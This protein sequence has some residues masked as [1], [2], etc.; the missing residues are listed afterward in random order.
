[1]RFVRDAKA[2]RM[3]TSA[4]VEGIFEVAEGFGAL[5][6]SHRPA[7]K[8]PAFH[9]SMNPDFYADEVDRA[10]AQQYALLG[11]L[12]VR[13]PNAETLAQLTRLQGTPTPLGLTHI[14]LAEA[15]GAVS[16]AEARSEFF[17]LFIGVGRGELMPYASYYLT[18]FL[19][20]LPLA[21]LRE[22]LGRLGLARAEKHYDPEDHIG[23]LCEI[24]SGLADGSLG[25]PAAEAKPFFARHLAPWAGRFFT[26][27]EMSKTGKF[28]RAVG[29][30]GRT[31]ME[32]EAEAFALDD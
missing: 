29:A 18:G 6:A 4:G 22:D 17:G 1:L 9:E 24:M 7:P 5:P 27:L 32:I 19:Q 12:L 11:A 28:Y 2:R 26:D 14:A 15:A 16:E 21:R 20:D 30:V 3:K 8:V 10:R 23:T 13:A 31:F 25:L